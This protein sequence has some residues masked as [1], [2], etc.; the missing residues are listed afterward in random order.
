MPAFLTLV[1]ASQFVLAALTLFLPVSFAGWMGLT[2]PPADSGYLM[3]ML[4][5]R[6]LAYGFGM[7]HLIRHPSRYW[8]GSMVLI[9]A[10]DFIAGA[11]YLGQGTVSLATVAFPMTNAAIFALGL[12]WRLRG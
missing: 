1:A 3:A 5:A 10:V 12:A 7:L 9:Q 8:L 11:A 6:F 4:G 2:P